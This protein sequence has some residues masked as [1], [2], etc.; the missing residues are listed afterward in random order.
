MIAILFLSILLAIRACAAGIGMATALSIGET[1]MLIG[2]F[3]GLFRRSVIAVLILPMFLL[4][5][6]W[7]VPSSS[8]S[9]AD[10]SSY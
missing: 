1:L 8:G 7:I 5:A 3:L 10:G 2:L 9:S 6:L 4:L